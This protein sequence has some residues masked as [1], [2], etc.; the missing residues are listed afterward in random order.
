[1][2]HLPTSNPLLTDVKTS[3]S[4]LLLKDDQAQG[5]TVFFQITQSHLLLSE[6]ETGAISSHFLLAH[7]Q[8]QRLSPEQICV[9]LPQEQKLLITEPEAYLL[10]QQCLSTHQ[11]NI[12]FYLNSVKRYV[13]SPLRREVINTLFWLFC[14]LALAYWILLP[15]G[16]NLLAEQVPQSWLSSLDQAVLTENDI[17]ESTLPPDLEKRKTTLLKN[18]EQYPSLI[19]DQENHP[20]TTPDLI[21]FDQ[22]K[23]QPPNAFALPGGH[24]VFNQSII[25]LLT[26]EE[27]LAVLAHELVHV[28][29][30]HGIRSVIQ[31]SGIAV[32]WSAYLGDVSALAQEAG[33]LLLIQKNSRAFEQE[34]DL[35]AVK[36]LEKIGLSKDLL[37]STLT[38]LKNHP[39]SDVDTDSAWRSHPSVL[40]RTRAIQNE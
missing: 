5:M 15:I 10:E 29:Q 36:K 16:A 2:N 31:A 26:D 39:S 25:N 13:V 22:T 7:V 34:A 27:L 24:I 40:Q 38:K 3:G 33:T 9:H 37:I 35:L 19:Q 23:N 18:L 14:I 28:E 1:M 8:L 21:W 20:I 4:A 12:L 30:R 32:L 17:Q 6:K 11:K